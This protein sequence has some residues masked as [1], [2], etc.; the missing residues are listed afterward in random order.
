M[1]MNP[2]QEADKEADKEANNNASVP[3]QAA[4]EEFVDSKQ[5]QIDALDNLAYSYARAG[6]DIIEEMDEKKDIKSDPGWVR[7]ERKEEKQSLLQ[8]RDTIIKRLRAKAK[9]NQRKLIA[10]IKRHNPVQIMAH[11]RDIITNEE[12]SELKTVCFKL[13][14][15]R[16]NGTNYVRDRIRVCNQRIKALR[17]Q[18]Y[19]YGLRMLK[20]W[21]AAPASVK[22]HVKEE[23]VQIIKEYM[24]LRDRPLEVIKARQ[25]ADKRNK[26]EKRN[27]AARGY[28]EW[29]VRGF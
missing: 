28:E 17:K 7:A 29:T 12:L 26:Q 8:K 25:E 19:N 20:I 23:T 6:G 5:D 13:D 10:A 21:L 22:E 15:M 16:N 18:Q 3:V 11:S 27:K 2:D 1:T 14:L 4:S 9:N 24:E